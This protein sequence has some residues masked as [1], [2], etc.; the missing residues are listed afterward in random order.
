MRD[1]LSR[2]RQ[3]IQAHPARASS[4]P[5]WDEQWPSSAPPSPA[6][7]TQ[8]SFVHPT[9]FPSLSS[10]GPTAHYTL[11]K[12]PSAPSLSVPATPQPH[13]PTALSAPPHPLPRQIPV[14]VLNYAA[15][16]PWVGCAVHRR[17]GSAIRDPADVGCRRRGRG[18]GGLR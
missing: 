9:A 2:S 6:E 3:L 8:S 12:P 4:P 18:R 1:H 14:S 17:L 13:N 15:S 11:S 7:S 16:L 10:L 5:E